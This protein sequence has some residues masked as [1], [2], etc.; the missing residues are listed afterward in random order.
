MQAAETS[1]AILAQWGAP[2]AIILV[3]FGAIFWLAKQL[4][5]SNDKIV[6]AMRVG[7]T[8][9]ETSDEKNRVALAEQ[10]KAILASTKASEE[11]T[12]AIRELKA[13]G[14]AQTAAID[15]INESVTGIIKDALARRSAASSQH[16]QAVK[17]P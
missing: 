2:G 12:A 6:D 9:K 11:Q 10:T 5:A 8:S 16:I 3:Q 15:R 7:M 13:T 14:G 1:G 4:L 17:A